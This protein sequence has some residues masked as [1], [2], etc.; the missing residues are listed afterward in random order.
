M[1]DVKKNTQNLEQSFMEVKN[2]FLK[3]CCLS[4]DTQPYF[5][6]PQCF[7]LFFC[8]YE[9]NFKNTKTYCHSSSLLLLSRL[10]MCHKSNKSL[11]CNKFYTRYCF[12]QQN[13]EIPSFLLRLL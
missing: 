5:H 8:L 12:L 2:M 7:T 1:T 10:L 6:T 4:I 11:F 13:L 9:I 3:V